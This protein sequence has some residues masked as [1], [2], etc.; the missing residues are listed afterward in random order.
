MGGNKLDCTYNDEVILK[1]KEIYRQEFPKYIYIADSK[2]LT[3]PNFISL[4]EGDQPIRFISRIPENFS[5]KIAEKIRARAFE[6][7]NWV[8]LGYCCNYPNDSEFVT[9]QAC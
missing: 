5:K 6:E 3:E 1:L 2:L 8:S 7:D 4:T 9:I